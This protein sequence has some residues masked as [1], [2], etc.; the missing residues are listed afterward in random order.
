MAKTDYWSERG[1]KKGRKVTDA[2]EDFPVLCS[3][4]ECEKRRLTVRS[5]AAA[6]SLLCNV[7]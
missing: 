3:T 2:K 5:L 7:P 6:A 1:R 4:R